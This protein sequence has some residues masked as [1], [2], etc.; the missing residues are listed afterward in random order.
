MT[1]WPIPTMPDVYDVIAE[2]KVALYSTLDLRAGYNQV[3][4]DPATAHKTAFQTHEG[5]FVHNRLSFG[6][7]YAVSFLQMVMSRILSN[8]TSSA[9]V[10]IYVDDIL[11]QGK[12]P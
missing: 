11:V 4:F 9:A 2:Q 1:S 12:T 5:K 7:C 3:M 8:M 6:L 10:L